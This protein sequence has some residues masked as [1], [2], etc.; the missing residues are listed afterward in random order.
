MQESSSFADVKTG[1][2]LVYREH[3]YLLTAAGTWFIFLWI[4]RL[5]NHAAASSYLII[6]FKQQG[7]DACTNCGILVQMHILA[8]NTE[9]WPKRRHAAPERLWYV[10]SGSGRKQRMDSFSERVQ[11]STFRRPHDGASHT[12]SPDFQTYNTGRFGASS[13]CQVRALPAVVTVVGTARVAV[14]RVY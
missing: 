10:C 5:P 12:V 7:W 4:I 8:P 1:R 9:N 3:L 6:A 14:F 11:L 2:F 13:K